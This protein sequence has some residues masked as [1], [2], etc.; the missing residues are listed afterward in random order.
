MPASLK[1]IGEYVFSGCSNLAS[2]SLNTG[3]ETIGRNAFSGTAI[4]EI[5]IPYTVKSMYDRY[6]GWYYSCF[7]GAEN[8]K[9]VIFADGMTDIP[10][11]ALGAESTSSSCKS[12]EEVV[13][14]STVQ[15]IGQYAFNGC[16]GLTSIEITSE[17]IAAS[18]TSFTNC[19]KLVIR[20]I[21]SSTIIDYCVENDIPFI[22]LNSAQV[23]QPTVDDSVLDVRNSS[24]DFL[25]T[26]IV[27]GTATVIVRYK[28]NDISG[29]TD[30]KIKVLLPNGAEFISTTLKV[31][32]VSS[33]DYTYTASS[34]TLLIPV[35]AN[36]GTAKFAIKL[37]ANSVLQSYAKL[38]CKKNGTAKEETIGVLT[39]TTDIL[40][41][42]APS[43]VNSASV[44]VSGVAPSRAS[45]EI[46]IDG[47]VVANTTASLNGVYTANITIPNPSDLTNYEIS[48]STT[49]GGRTTVSTTLVS[50]Y[51]DDVIDVSEF[52]LYYNNHN[53]VDLL[54]TNGKRP[55]VSFNP[56]YPM[57]FVVDTDDNSDIQTVNIVSTKNGVIKKIPATYDETTDTF[58]ASGYFDPNNHS[59]VP[60]ELSVEYSKKSDQV[61]FTSVPSYTSV[62]YASQLAENNVTFSTNEISD[63]EVEFTFNI[64][65]KEYKQTFTKEQIYDKVTGKLADLTDDYAKA[66]GFSE[67][68]D[69]NDV[70]YFAKVISPYNST[71]DKVKNGFEI[72]KNHDSQ[73]VRLYFDDD[74]G[75]AFDYL[76]ITIVTPANKTI[77][78]A[79][80]L[81][82]GAKT[83]NEYD[84]IY[85]NIMMDESLS[86]SERQARVNLCNYGYLM[87]G[88]ATI[89][90]VG[91][92]MFA[93]VG[94]VVAGPWAI[95][96]GIVLG[97]MTYASNESMKAL[98][99]ED[100]FT[101]FINAFSWLNWLVDP[102][103]YVYEA[104]DSNRLEGVTTTIY[105]K[106]AETGV[107]TLWDADEYD[108]LNPL[109]T[110]AE[111]TYAW[112][113]PEGLWQV[114]YEKSG[115]E[116]TYSEWLPVPPPQLD[117]NI[118]MKSTTAPSV[119]LVNVYED[120][121][122]ISFSQY[123]DVSTVTTSNVKLSQDG[124]TLI[125]TLTPVN[126]EGKPGEPSIQYASVFRLQFNSSIKSTSPVTVNIS[127]V[128]N[129]CG[130]TLINNYSD[131][132]DVKSKIT[133]V[134]VPDNI[135]VDY[136]N[137]ATLTIKAA[138][139]SAVNGK[140]LNV[141]LSNGFTIE[142]AENVEF[143]ER[144]IATLVITPK[145]PGAVDIELSIEDTII[146]VKRTITVL[147]NYLFND[148]DHVD[149]DADGFCDN[150]GIEMNTIFTGE[151][152]YCEYCGNYHNG[153]F[154]RII[155]F[156]HKL[157][158]TLKNMFSAIKTAP[159]E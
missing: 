131:N 102:S 8:L 108:Q 89:G 76:V 147:Q 152:V 51:E 91:L 36:S 63:D 9:K 118:A 126:A 47:S 127:G 22:I 129:Y 145:L 94:G 151:S 3:L 46:K 79:K 114:K 130:K 12:V 55:T 44:A 150:C 103:G 11:C 78:I 133:D 110:S 98:R 18:N 124:K 65:G 81:Y 84:D 10:M 43:K 96:A 123:M 15:K 13:L 17:I 88:L 95:A 90:K 16:V 7:T 70:K 19:P 143:D 136:I 58:I 135:E 116:T 20:T 154:G 142:T 69:G 132:T 97:A 86:E 138:P 50:Y 121:A 117:V 72:F 61:S 66:H 5:T 113:V 25:T 1:T 41:V 37:P 64:L 45:V 35:T 32:D 56:S 57:T 134:I 59:Y 26:S 74:I 21:P 80:D 100:A 93:L 49:L 107:V 23:E 33:S 71:G 62:D 111:G 83:S 38:N 125:G 29:V 144:G 106:D 87:N 24:Y 27:N 141:S 53:A 140:T 158:Y 115:Y 92:G 52:K 128:K 149:D 77:G 112:D 31:N 34:N 157:I 109:S 6:G 159:T 48:A 60:G 2:V 105:F 39:S 137:G 155:S 148:C 153:F 4:T 104:V 101:Q 30:K 119:E 99:G 14:P 40:T 82:K 120:S 73:I 67:I 156:F 68:V 75:D 28:T 146:T 42:N 139:A 54:N 85:W 122:E